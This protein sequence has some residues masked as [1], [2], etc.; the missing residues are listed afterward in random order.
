MPPR[1]SQI[2]FWKNHEERVCEVIAYA[3]VLLQKR[4][5]LIQNEDTLNREFFFCL[6][7]A[8]NHMVRQGKGLST[9]FYYEA[10]NQPSAIHN[11]EKRERE[12]KRPDFQN[13]FVDHSES[14][15]EKQ[16]KH[17]CV[18]C[19]RLGDAPSKSW[20]INRNYI[21]NG[22]TRF[23][24]IEH[25]YGLD[26]ESGAMIGYVESSSFEIILKEVNITLNEIN[27]NLPS[28]PSDL[29][30]DDNN[31]NLL[32]HTLTRDFPISPFKLCHFWVD[33]RGRLKPAPSK[34]KSNKSSITDDKSA[35]ANSRNNDIDAQDTT[36]DV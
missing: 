21:L 20:Q 2:N 11:N 35:E 13:G 9:P 17:F 31:A 18:E 26:V 6:R 29:K 5:N 3:L 22:V 15:P 7:E 1:L 14:D 4:D 10:R 25:G 27:P 28:L 19:K 24:T 12:D 16:D 36:I 33:L 32:E 34:T 30:W 23:L 8:N